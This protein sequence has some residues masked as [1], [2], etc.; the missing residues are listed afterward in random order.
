[1]A[2]KFFEIAFNGVIQ[3]G[4]ELDSVKQKLGQMFKADEARLAHMFSGKRVFIKRRADEITMI[5][6]RAAFQKAGA[7]CEIVELA[8]EPVAATP[9]EREQSFAEGASNTVAQNQNGEEYVSKYPESDQVPQA[10]LTE[11]LGVSAEQ[12]DDL[13]AGLAP[14]GSML[15]ADYHEP[16]EPKIDISGMDVAPVGSDLTSGQRVAAPPPP[17]TSSLTLAD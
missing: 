3:P 5:K 10:L 12:I 8:D 7:I 16:P 15:L 1:M 17:D 13:A 4:A 6:F 14:V 9:V 11:P 2:E